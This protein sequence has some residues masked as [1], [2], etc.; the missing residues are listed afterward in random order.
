MTHPAI[1]GLSAASTTLL[2]FMLTMQRSPVF[3]IFL[4]ESW[5]N[6]KSLFLMKISLY[7]DIH[8]HIHGGVGQF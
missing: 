3:W 6:E 2:L 1:L 5:T 4:V 8:D 7:N